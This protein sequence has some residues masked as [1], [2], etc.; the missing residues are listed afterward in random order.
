M[1]AEYGV[2][3]YIYG[4][5]AAVCVSIHIAATTTYR[6]IRPQGIYRRQPFESHRQRRHSTSITIN[7]RNFISVIALAGAATQLAAAQSPDLIG[8]AVSNNQRNGVGYEVKQD[9]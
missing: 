9:N 2:K 4:L 6:S 7:M 1:N 8:C 5:I 3:S